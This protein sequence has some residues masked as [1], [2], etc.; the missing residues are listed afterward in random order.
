MHSSLP[1]Q[2]S[3]LE[4]LRQVSRPVMAVAT[5][6]MVAAFATGCGGNDL[7]AGSLDKQFGKASDGTP[8]GIVSLSL[9]SGDDS[10]KGMVVQADGKIVVAGYSTSGGSNNFA[11]VRYNANGILDTTFS[12]RSVTPS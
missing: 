1:T 6:L 12:L 8:D 4:R 2:R 11:V 3:G 5:G 7:L 9:G 10:A